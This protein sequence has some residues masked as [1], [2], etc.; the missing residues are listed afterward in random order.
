MKR[1]VAISSAILLSAMVFVA[2][3]YGEGY[4]GKPELL[5]KRTLTT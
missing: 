3:A 4:A 2:M 1:A 5:G